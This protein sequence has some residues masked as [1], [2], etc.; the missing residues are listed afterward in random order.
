MS[1]LSYQFLSERFCR[2]DFALFEAI[3]NQFSTFYVPYLMCHIRHSSIMFWA[4]P[5]RWLIIPFLA[6]LGP[7]SRL[8]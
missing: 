2:S 4:A 8:K 6:F 3:N 5:D 1:V 7:I